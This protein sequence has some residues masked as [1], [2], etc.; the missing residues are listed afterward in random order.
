M[1]S[2][3]INFLKDR[4]L[5]QSAVGSGNKAPKVPTP[6]NAMIPLYIGLAVLILVPGITGGIWYFLTQ[7]TT[8]SQAKID[9]LKTELKTLEEQGKKFDELKIDLKIVEASNK[10]IATTLATVMPWSA[11]FEDLRD[12]IP[13]G[14]K[15]KSIQQNVQVPL[16]I[17]LQGYADSYDTL[18]DFL[19]TLQQSPFVMAST[20]SIAEAKLIENPLTV[21]S[22]TGLSIKLP[23]VVEYSINLNLT[24]SPSFALVQELDRKGAI[25]LVTRLK[26]LSQKGVTP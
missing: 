6:M 1:Y 20:T 26:T 14:V 12:R 24:D 3:D 19:L 2:I 18:N 10:N 9:E 15:I 13:Q 25:G 23:Q 11:I 8:Q 5:D 21:T 17:T 16:N 4:N 7:Q 22:T